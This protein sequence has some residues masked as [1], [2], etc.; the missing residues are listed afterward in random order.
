MFML[1]ELLEELQYTQSEYYRRD[2]AHFEPETVHWFCL[3]RAAGGD[4]LYM[5]QTNADTRNYR[6]AVLVAEARDEAEARAIHQRTW[7]IGAIPFLII[8]LP[9]Q[10]R[11]YTGFDYS[12]RDEEQGKL[13][14]V[15]V[16][17][18]QLASILASFSSE[19][20]DTGKIWKSDY[21]T[22]LFPEQRVD[23]RLLKSLKELKNLLQEEATLPLP[24]IHALIGKY[25]YIRY[26]WDRHIITEQWMQAHSIDK[27]KIFGRDATVETLARLVDA[28]EQRFNG[29]VFP[30]DFANHDMLKDSHVSMIASVFQGDMLVS[31]DGISLIQQLHLEFQAYDFCYI[32]VETLSVVYEQ[33]IEKREAKG[34]FYTPE[35]LADYV[36]SEVHTHNPLHKDMHILD[37]ACGSGIFLVL[38]YR[39]LIEQERALHPK[40][41]LSPETLKT[42]L[43]AIYGVEREEDACYVTEFSLILT[44]LHYLEPP[45]LD[46]HPEF[47]FPC[48]HNTHIFVG[49]FFDD[50][51]AFW[52][53]GVHFD[54]VVGNPPWIKTT[55]KKKQDQANA[56]Q[57]IRNHKD[58]KPVGVQSV[59][60][61]FSWRVMDVLQP[62]GIVGMLLPAT[63][64]VNILSL[65]YRQAFFR[66]HEV[67]RITNFANIRDVLFKGGQRE[68]GGE[69]SAASLIYRKLSITGRKPD[70][71]HCSP[72]SINQQSSQ[73]PTKNDQQ[74]WSIILHEH[75]IKYIDPYEAEQGETIT[76]KIALWGTYRDRRAIEQLRFLFPMTLE[77]F[78]E[79]KGW[80]SKMPRQGAEFCP[81]PKKPEA[82]IKGQN[83]FSTKDFMQSGCSFSL[84]NSALQKV[85]QD[86]HIRCG[87]ETL[88]LTTAAPHVI[89]SK[90]WDFIL[91]SNRDFIIPPQ[92]LGIAGTAKDI[93]YLQAL[94]MYLNSS[95]V[96]Y[97]LFFQVPEWGF[98]SQRNRVL[99]SQVRT[100][101]TPDFTLEQAEE[102]AALQ[103]KCAAQETELIQQGES[104][105]KFHAEQQTLLDETIA[106]LFAIPD[107][108]M[109][110]AKEFVQVRLPLDKGRAD[111]ARIT[112]DPTKDELLAYTQTLRNELDGFTMGEKY[113][114]VTIIHSQELIVCCIEL[115]D[116]KEPISITEESIQE[117][118]ISLIEMLRIIR[119]NIGQQFSQ[120]VYV[121][122]GLR[123]FHGNRILLCK[124]PRLIDWSQTQAMQDANDIIGQ[125]IE[126]RMGNS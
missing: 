15:S 82:L 57:W 67:L 3:V 88:R 7:N 52:N 40:K 9:H 61:A 94:A 78:C 25:V 109:T 42:L 23:S 10:V 47:H 107:D 64:L 29:R 73:S 14:T 48:L 11:V 83:R 16:D 41:N 65:H 34:A 56:Y 75:D 27:G 85:Q 105:E 97:Y 108:L 19:A 103:V 118:D 72:L 45:E 53:S 33:F 110:L 30:I 92:Q 13:D 87:E 120:W 77:H 76:W 17:R 18:Q 49:D 51:S 63:S 79:Q 100:I 1:Q 98:Y 91:Y 114:R 58:E 32:P 60:E 35:I 22:S 124:S 96:H 44:L 106:R 62:Q 24:L 55:G 6:P 46:N 90:G 21:A 95:L 81:D 4:G 38:A 113:H 68:D 12:A 89:L 102:L 112:K 86:A 93:S 125:A 37:P 26:L 84:P 122:R 126:T 39:R 115:T 71:I 119:Q 104:I 74:L 20:I 59:A 121:Q 80:G 54:W 70:I 116:S 2:E 31:Y 69:M 28:L 101:P 8:I 123:L 43:K 50:T 111:R 5:Y 66:Q 117:G 99:T 36:L